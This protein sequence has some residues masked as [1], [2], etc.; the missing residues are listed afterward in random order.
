M[1]TAQAAETM[2]VPPF[3]MERWQSHFEHGVRFNLSDSGVHPLRLHE[4][5]ELADVD[6]G[7][8]PLEY[9]QTNGTGPLRERI[10]ALH[11]GADASN[12]V[13]TSG[14]AE[15]NFVT[16]WRMVEP[17]DRVVILTPT[18]GQTPGLA[19][20]LGAEVV[21]FELEEARG[22]HPPPGAGPDSITPGTKLVVVTNPN[23]P[24]G[25]R[26][27][28]EAMDEIVAAA[29]LAGAWILADEV[30]RGAELDGTETSSFWGRTDRVVVSGSLSKAYG[31]PG[32]RLGW[33]VGPAVEMEGLWG[34]KDYT[35]ICPAALSDFLGQAALRSD[36]RARLLAR[37]RDLLRTN[38]SLVA[39]LVAA[40]DG[41]LSWH[42]PA[43][44]AISYLRYA[45]DSNSTRLA[46]QLR[47]EH[48]VLVVPGDHFGMDGYLR[49]G[50]GVE[51][52]ELR[53]ALARLESC[54]AVAAAAGHRG[55]TGN[56]RPRSTIELRRGS[57]G[58]SGATRRS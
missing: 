19:A 34:R 43:A 27:T 53:A 29:E 32:L 23:N 55:L 26:L 8:M 22:W 3:L 31:L 48:D 25:S 18:Y 12:V 16:L 4:F 11:P 33:L 46:E 15:A 6:P 36:V 40:L 56:D 49:I 47:Q 20:G 10:T 57:G 42:P 35:T 39:E 14:S 1:L 52:E 28:S 38:R 13:A 45:M 17:G 54:I 9:T 41:I 7:P 37:A 21:T 44:G 5:L 24:T 51:T 30:Y 58:E 2:R 50:Y